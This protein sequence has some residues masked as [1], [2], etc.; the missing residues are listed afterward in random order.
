MEPV[1]VVTVLL[2]KIIIVIGQSASGKSTYVKNNFIKEPPA[3]IETPLKHTV[4]GTTMLLGDYLVN[5]R[6][7]GTDTLSYNVLDKII[8]LVKDGVGKYEVIVAEGDRIN[9][10][11][12]F[13]EVSKLMI[14]TTL[15]VFSCSVE[16]SM[17]RLSKEGSSIKEPFV[18]TTKTKSNSMK[19]LGKRLG[20][21]VITINTGEENN[22]LNF[23]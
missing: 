23:N 15:Y 12:F 22:L 16:E 7:V 3:L 18:K 17:K 2:S 21:N 19:L 13:E 4:S 5:R 14:P 9:N 6:C 11:K 1:G 10:S 20:F 8:E